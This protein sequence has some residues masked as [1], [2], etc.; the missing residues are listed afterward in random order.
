MEILVE[1]L[2]V[3]SSG[4]LE[5]LFGDYGWQLARDERRC[6]THRVELSFDVIKL[7]SPA[8]DVGV[9]H[10]SGQRF[11]PLKGDTEGCGAVGL[12]ELGG[13]AAIGQDHD[14]RGSGDCEQDAMCLDC[15]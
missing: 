6:T 7:R 13:V 10:D 14:R 1:C 3:P 5:D 12:K 2:Q 15:R 9:D 11:G 8:V 4:D